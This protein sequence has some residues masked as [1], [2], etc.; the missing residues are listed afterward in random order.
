MNHFDSIFD[1]ILHYID[2][3]VLK[4]T[5]IP[6]TTIRNIVYNY[7]DFGEYPVIIP[8][9]LKQVITYLQQLIDICDNIYLKVDT[10]RHFGK[11]MLRGGLSEDFQHSSRLKLD[12]VYT[13]NHT[14][15][16][17][18][19]APVQNRFGNTVYKIKLNGHICDSYEDMIQYIMDQYL[20]ESGYW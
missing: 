4:N 1:E 8:R 6:Y 10:I 9:D 2:N 19:F 15:M 13:T 18:D 17:L 14:I 5:T 7:A 11:P 16:I 12:L 20:R 3:G